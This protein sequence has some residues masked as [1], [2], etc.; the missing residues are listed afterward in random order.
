MKKK[1]AN[2]TLGTKTAL[3]ATGAL[4]AIS[5]GG[6][7]A[8]Y[9]EHKADQI[10]TVLAADT[11]VVN[12][13]RTLQINVSELDNAQTNY[14]LTLNPTWKIQ[15][16]ANITTINNTTAE[17]QNSQPALSATDRTMLDAVQTWIDETVQPGLYMAGQVGEGKQPKTALAPYVRQATSVGADE[18]VGAQVAQTVDVSHAQ[19]IR[20]QEAAELDRQI[21]R[22][23]LALGAVFATLAVIIVTML[24]MF[25]RNLKRR[26]GT[27]EHSAQ[28][29]GDGNLDI[30]V[31]ADGT[32]ELGKL[33]ATVEM[34]RTELVKNEEEKNC[35]TTAKPPSTVFETCV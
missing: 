34:L 8:W 20:A 3:A 23:Q 9:S 29:I 4:L 16:D 26:V 32:D 11:A 22:A 10:N 13:L 27:L 15:A 17:L 21:D 7:V 14:L 31:S 12:S 19:K 35:T 24:I 6:T 18:D 2:T 30:E 5:V 33:G 1:L 28:A 25:G